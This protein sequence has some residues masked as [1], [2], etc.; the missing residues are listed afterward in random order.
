[1]STCSRPPSGGT[2]AAGGIIG[3]PR[4][5]GRS[6]ASAPSQYHVRGPRRP[7]DVKDVKHQCGNRDQDINE[8]LCAGI[9][10]QSNSLDLPE[11]NEHFGHT[12]VF[13]Y[14][15]RLVIREAESSLGATTPASMSSMQR[16][17]L[18]ISP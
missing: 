18:R 2:A 7:I 3:I 9:R 16:V 17:V 4:S 14:S 1:M 11:A 6:A 10:T 12:Q 5:V 13:W 15:T 8:P